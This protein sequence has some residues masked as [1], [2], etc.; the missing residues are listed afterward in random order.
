MEQATKEM[1]GQFEDV[2]ETPQGPGGKRHIVN[3]NY[4]VLS[5]EQIAVIDN[6]KVIDLHPSLPAPR[7]TLE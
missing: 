1:G 5:D 3:I 6:A 2:T 4:P 7:H